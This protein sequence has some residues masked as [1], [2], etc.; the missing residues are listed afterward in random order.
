MRWR[1]RLTAAP[2][3][4]VY[5]R[6][7]FLFSRVKKLRTCNEIRGALLTTP[8][9]IT[10]PKGRCTC[11]S[12][13]TRQAG[14]RR[15]RSL[16]GTPIPKTHER[17]ENKSRIYEVG[18]ERAR[19]WEGRPGGEEIETK[20]AG[21]T[22]RPCGSFPFK[23]PISTQQRAEVDGPVVYASQTKKTQE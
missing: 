19:V 4:V 22:L 15:R 7:L 10:T 14:D 9:H 1:R 17:E 2:E 18:R 12:R 16:G 6:S 20:F 3:H 8:P 13:Q 21:A 11:S 5:R 23:F